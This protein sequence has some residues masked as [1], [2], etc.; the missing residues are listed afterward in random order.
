MD[1]MQ[2]INERHSVRSFT[3]KRIEGDVEAALRAAIDECNAESGLHIQLCLDEPEA[4]GGFMARYGRFVNCK[5]YLALVGGVG[6]EEKCGYY[7]EKLALLA[8]TLGLNTCWVALTFSKAAAKRYCEI[9]S[10]EKLIIVI[11]LGYG[12]TQGSPRKSKDMASLC[13]VEGETPDWFKEGMRAAMLAPTAINQQRFLIELSNG[14]VRAETLGGPSS[15]IDLGIVKY[16]FEIG[17]RGGDW[18]WG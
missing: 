6:C 4:F 10:G 9:A 12:T 18:R 11:A 15:K 2:A 3:D 16:H 7:G 5:N 1:I 8:Q 13:R 17:A 14:V